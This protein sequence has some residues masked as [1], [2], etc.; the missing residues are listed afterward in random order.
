MTQPNRL[1]SEFNVP[2]EPSKNSLGFPLA[3]APFPLAVEASLCVMM[4]TQI[5][6]G[7]HSGGRIKL[8]AKVASLF[9]RDLPFNTVVHCLGW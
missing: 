9:F 1:G 5:L 3:P 8:D 4:W 7:I 2:N 6:W